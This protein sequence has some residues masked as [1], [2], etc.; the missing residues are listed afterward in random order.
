M[1]EEGLLAP[2]FS[3]SPQPKISIR[4]LRG[5]S[6]QGCTHTNSDF[7]LSK[8]SQRSN[9]PLSKK[10][11]QAQIPACPHCHQELPQKSQLQSIPA[12]VTF[13]YS[14]PAPLPEKSN[15]YN[16]KTHVTPP[17]AQPHTQ[18][19]PVRLAQET[20][21]PKQL[22]ESIEKEFKNILDFGDNNGR[23]EYTYGE[24]FPI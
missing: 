11:T 18:A 10:T 3:H 16:V 17:L 5:Q 22:D 4:R 24:A 13:L 15:N 14:N 9:I 23:E 2:G 12:N 7:S 19:A 21:K 8:Q 1:E 20:A 6:P